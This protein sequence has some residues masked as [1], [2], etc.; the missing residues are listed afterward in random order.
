MQSALGDRRLLVCYIPGLDARR[1]SP[2]ATPAIAALIDRYPSVRLFTV[3]NTEL[4]PTLLSGVYPHEN[5][6]WQVSV[7]GRPSPTLAQRAIDTLP[8]L[9]TTTLQCVKQR[10]DADFDLAAIPPRRRRR[11]THHRL[12][13]TRR[14][15]S[16]ETLAE[17]NGYETLFGLLGD[18]A[19]Y[20][21]TSKFD[22]LDALA[23]E[24]P[25]TGLRLEFLEMYALDLHQHWHLDNADA[26]RESLR[27]TDRFVAQLQ[28]RCADDGCTFVLLSDHGQEAV[29]NT[30]PLVPLLRRCGVRSSD[31][32]YYCELACARLWFHTERARAVILPEL[33]SLERCRV[34]HFSEMHEYQIRFEDDRFGEY[35]VM[36]DAGSIFF[37]H[38]FYQ[39]VANLYLGLFGAS[40]RARVRNP[41]HRGNH[42]YLPENP[43][44]QGFMVVA[45]AAAAPKRRDMAL[46]DFA[47]SILA[48]L[49]HPVPPYMAGESVL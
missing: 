21:F 43:S 5:E 3:P 28:E 47:P 1:I 48:Y 15:A 46:I 45:D 18:R 41:V 31:Y 24:L 36:A 42:G 29:T 4:V 25:S 37:P 38:D 26:M 40:Q 49:E 8:D 34:L 19:R 7:D 27:R 12:K 39:P 20:R 11:F 16:P 17:F 9:L 23:Q 33:E 10:F 35:Y 14:M 30:I 2:T 44:E 6:V 13:Y 22:S 32:T